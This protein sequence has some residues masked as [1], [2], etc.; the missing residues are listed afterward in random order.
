MRDSHTLIA[1]WVGRRLKELRGGRTQKEF[2][3]LLGLS[4]A[5]YNRYETGKRLAH[6]KVLEQV[7]V[8]CGL[9]LEQVVW[10]DELPAG[11]Q[12][13]L[14]AARELA[15]LMALLDEAAL[16]D[17]FVFLRH[18]TQ[19]LARQRRAEARQALKALEGFGKKALG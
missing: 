5:H 14:E 19:E 6:D 18:K 9:S 4:Q 16:E 17:L 10:G 12:P 13:Q 7:A 11:A 3:D 2:A 8:V 1:A 15:A